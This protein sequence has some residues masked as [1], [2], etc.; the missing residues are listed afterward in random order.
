MSGQGSFAQRAAALANRTPEVEIWDDDLDFQ[1]DVFLKSTASIPPSVSSKLSVRSE[2]VAG[3]ED[4]QVLIKPNDDQSKQIAISSAKQ[5]GIPIPLNVPS[6]ALLGGTIKRLGKKDSRRKLVA[7]DDWAEDLDLASGPATLKLKQPTPKTPALDQDDSEDWGEGS[8]GIRFAGTQRGGDGR[9]RSS[10]VSAMSPSMG[11]CMTLESEDDEL[12]GILLPNEP[13]DFNAR[14]AKVKFRE[15]ED[16]QVQE[17]TSA[18]KLQQQSPLQ[19]ASSPIPRSTQHADEGDDFLTGIEFGPGV[20]LD[21]KKGTLNRNVKIKTESSRAQTPALRH[22]TTLTFT[23]KPSVSKIPRPLNTKPSRL[24]PVY[25]SGAPHLGRHQRPVPTTTN[26][27]LL[28]AKRSA[29][30]LRNNYGSTAKPPVPFLPAG[31]STQSHHVTAK[32][33]SSQLRRDS[34]PNRAKSPPMRTYSRMSSLNVPETPSRTSNRKDIAPAALVREATTKRSMTKPVKKQAYGNGTEL[35]V[36]DDLPTS[37][38]KESKFVKQP[39][40]KPA[41]MKPLRQQN[42]ITGLHHHDRTVTPHPPQTPRSPTKVHETTPRFARDTAASRIAREQRLAGTRSRAE[43]PLNQIHTNWK[44]QVAARSPQNSPTSNRVKGSGK[45]PQLIKPMGISLPKN[46]KGM[47]YNPIMQRW[48]GNEG[49]L[50]PFTLANN[51]TSTLASATLTPALST[52]TFAPHTHHHHSIHHQHSHSNPL[53]HPSNMP[54][55]NPPSPPRQPALIHHKSQPLGVRVDNGM[56]FDPRQ[57][58]WLKLGRSPSGLYEGSP[59]VDEEE[60][61]FA[62]IEDLKDDSTR[63]SVG[64]GASTGNAAIDDNSFVGEEFDVGPAFR[65][66]QKDEEATWRRMVGAWFP[67]SPTGS[68]VEVQDHRYELWNIVNQSAGHR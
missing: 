28:K 47:T 64:A 46:E 8:L 39:T 38:V 5:A 67:D 7:D 9:N 17:F 33:S 26:A 11:S 35:D 6:S 43:G 66:R 45:K 20:V 25:E 51:S 31:A 58:R 30:L 63:V 60:D 57:M 62:G 12:G 41:A 4:W 22:A 36:F 1:G 42:S 3:D 61:P 54:R 44:A 50:T 59:S 40:N 19:T 15:E 68:A 27:Q 10:S 21:P 24:D 29:P 23:D 18:P 48:E 32:Y 53:F 56:V 52:P 37:A 13:L 2:S 65:K 34:D 55:Q 14:L 49:A 16:S